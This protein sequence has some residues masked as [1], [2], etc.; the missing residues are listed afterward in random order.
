MNEAKGLPVIDLFLNPDRKKELDDL[1]D[2]VEQNEEWLTYTEV[3]KRKRIANY[4]RFSLAG[5]FLKN[6]PSHL[7]VA[8]AL[9]AHLHCLHGQPGLAPHAQQVLLEGRESQLL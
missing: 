7:R 3:M 5:V 6:L 1:Q 8:L 4:S 2:W 9:D